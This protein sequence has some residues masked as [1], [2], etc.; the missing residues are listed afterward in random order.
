[1]LT[2]RTEEIKQNI[3]AF[4]LKKFRDKINKNNLPVARL[5]KF[6][7]CE[8]LTR[9]VNLYYKDNEG[10]HSRVVDVPPMHTVIAYIKNDMVDCPMY[11]VNY[12][13]MYTT[14]EISMYMEYDIAKIN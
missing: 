11:Y 1:M 2:D 13:K 14:Y 3:I 5:Y 12:S 10:Q 4:E 8:L 7:L 9:H 6:V